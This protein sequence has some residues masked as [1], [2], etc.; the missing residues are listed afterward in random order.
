MGVYRP[1]AF[2]ALLNIGWMSPPSY[3]SAWLH[4]CIARFRFTWQVDCCFCCC[5][6]SPFSAEPAN[7]LGRM[8]GQGGDTDSS[9]A[10]AIAAACGW[11]RRELQG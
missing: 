3:P 7:F 9:G 10:R 2:P 11:M 1:M 4:P 8:R 5:V 6:S